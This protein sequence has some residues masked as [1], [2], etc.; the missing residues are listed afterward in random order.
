[1]YDYWPAL[2]WS[3][4]LPSRP[5]SRARRSRLRNPFGSSRNSKQ[6]FEQGMGVVV[7]QA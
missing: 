7:A 1:M 3:A 6:S 4:S 5:A 2:M